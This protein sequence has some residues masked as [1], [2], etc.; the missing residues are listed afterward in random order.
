MLIRGRELE[1]GEV[2][3]DSSV[4][5]QYVSA[6]MMIAP[7][8]EKGITIN[9]LNEIVSASYVRLTKNLMEMHEIPVELSGKRIRIPSCVFEARDIRV[10]GDW[11]AAGYW[12]SLAALCEEADI[13]IAGLGTGSYQGDAVLPELF[14]PLGVDTTATDEGVKL[15]RIRGTATGFEYHFGDS[16]DLVQTMAVV[17]AM[18]GIPFRMTGT[19]TLKIKET[20]R[21]VA[22][23]RELR[24][25]GFI[26]DADPAGSWI[27]WD[28]V[29]SE[30][31]ASPQIDTYQ[32]H[33]MAMAFAAAS[34]RFPGLVINEP[35]VVH[36]SYPGFWKDL[37]S[38]GFLISRLN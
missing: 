30:P 12:Y 8:L 36:K 37:E 4:S 27:A 22:L 6:L 14:R 34:I 38:V 9:L 13:E 17:C 31:S 20:D 19:K 11:S 33:S 24:K 2:S 15:G 32:D 18:L 5:S 3:I 23:Q 29:R 21:I 10:E 16:P 7:A 1:G 35:G 28:G 26:L 25:L